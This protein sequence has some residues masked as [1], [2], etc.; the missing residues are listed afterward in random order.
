ME[1][2][3]IEL[4]A[5]ITAEQ[6]GET[7]GLF[8]VKTANQWMKDAESMPAP[9]ALF[10]N[11]WSEGEVCI[12][13]ADT[14][15]GKSALAVQIADSITRGVKINGFDLEAKMQPVVYFDFE[16]STKQFS[17]RY[18]GP[19]GKYQF[20]D[21]FF[22]SEVDQFSL[23]GLS[24]TGN[25]EE[26]LTK[27]LEETII[28]RKAKICIIDNITYL[29]HQTEKAEF[30]LPLMKYLIRL[31]FKHNLTML[32]LAH[33]PKRDPYKEL[34]RN[35][36]QGSK[37]LINF[38]DSAFAIGE[39]HQDRRIRYLKQIKA[40]S[41]EIKYDNENVIN[42]ELTKSNDFLQF[43]FLSYGPEREHLKH[44]TD[45]DREQR[46]NQAIE[47]KEKGLS[48]HEISRRLGVSEGSVRYW[49]KE[50]TRK[51]A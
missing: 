3:S 49:L 9:C 1:K 2:L 27:S 6:T 23:S 45:E 46:V 30:A 13:F 22:R 14:N 40:R 25:F 12:L 16:L 47:L 20:N 24:E 10:D 17:L 4:D 15:T 8:K 26:F 43:E 37:M 42:C 48:N 39:N 5:N 31:K 28:N 38:C 7:I 11:F 33:T 29:K 50:K 19:G 44:L 35:D 21:N 36:L 34:S 51:D 18:S 32:V 41:A